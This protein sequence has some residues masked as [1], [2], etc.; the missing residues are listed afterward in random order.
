MKCG[1]IPTLAEAMQ[2][3]ASRGALSEAPELWRSLRF[4]ICGAS[5]AGDKWFDLSGY[6]NNGTLT[7][8]DPATDWVT[9]PYGRALDFDNVE[10]PQYVDIG[11]VVNGYPFSLLCLTR[12]DVATRGG[13]V[14]VASSADGSAVFS[15]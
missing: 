12:I 3:R 10:T 1:R 6:G 8:M 4:A 9:S 13:F 2:V 7:N 5:G 15:G 14:S 11:Q